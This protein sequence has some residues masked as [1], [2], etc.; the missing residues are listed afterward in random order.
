MAAGT[1]TI[2]SMTMNPAP[3]HNAVRLYVQWCAAV[4]SGQLPAP[5]GQRSSSACIREMDNNR[6]EMDTRA[7]RRNGASCPGAVRKSRQL[8]MCAN[9]RTSDT[10]LD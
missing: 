4:A 2:Q 1:I 3:A 8:A 7:T 9:C 6:E 10:S 5:A